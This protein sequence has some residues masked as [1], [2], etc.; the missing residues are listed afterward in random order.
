M[1]HMKETKRTNHEHIQNLEFGMAKLKAL[2]M[3]LKSLAGLGPAWLAGVI[4][5]TECVQHGRR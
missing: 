5:F 1:I 2:C 3:K 4:T